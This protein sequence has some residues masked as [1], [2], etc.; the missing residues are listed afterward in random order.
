MTP[1]A[2]VR[3]TFILTSAAV[4]PAET[5]AAIW[6]VD[7]A[8]TAGDGSAW[9]RPLRSV[10]AAVGRA[11]AGDE[12]WLRAGV[13]PVAEPLRLPRGVALVGGFAGHERQADERRGI[14]FA[15]ETTLRLTRPGASVLLLAGVRDVRLD[16]LTLTG[17]SQA[18]A[19]TVAGCGPE[20]RFTHV[21]ITGNSSAVA[22]AAIRITDGSEP[23]FFNCQFAD[24]TSTAPEGGG[25]IFV[26][27][28][29]G[30]S[31]D[32]CI[33]N[34]NV[35]AH[36]SGGGAQIH[37]GSTRA[38]RFARTDFY[39][40]TAAH[41]GSAL[42][43]AGPLELRDCVVAS[44][45]C[46]PAGPGHALAAPGA[47]AR[48]I[49]S[50]QSYVVSNV[51]GRDRPVLVRGIDG[52]ERATLRDGALIAPGDTG[53]ADPAL[54]TS[55]NDVHV[56]LH[57][58]FMPPLTTGAPAPGRWVRQTLPEYAGTAAYHCVYLPADWQ[59][60]RRFPV[61]AG[62]PGN[63]PY[64]NR[65]G[66]RSGGLPEDNPMGVGVSG[67]RGFIVL[68]LGYLDT[69][70]NLQPTG[71]WWGD[72]PA[73]LAYTQAAVRF[74]CGTYGGDPQ[75]IVLFG[76]SRSAIGA[77][78]LGLHDDTI[79]PLWRAFLCYDGWESQADMA[80]DWYRHG[81]SSFGYDPADFGGTGVAR[82]F[83]RL[84]GRPLF[85]LGGRGAVEALNEPHRFPVRLLA[86]PHRNH[87]TSWALRDT[88]ERAAIRDWLA[89]EVGLP[90]N[91]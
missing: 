27:A 71:N 15:R 50:G 79:A 55:R 38:V 25:G 69:R 42:S 44:N 89:R 84:A 31:W 85:I 91:P 83:A 4:L 36:G 28:S 16:G 18:P 81:R 40:N 62:F 9:T 58:V 20:V 87:H 11:R 47:A 78:F 75:A 29:S 5:A 32:L 49:L 37:G 43:T 80:R 59:P 41:T 65:Y 82:R 1:V 88:P 67:G 33:V 76:F 35:A 14:N 7:P 54:H 23:V 61:L 21:R 56:T 68:G 19:V 24:N 86:K 10:G 53:P 45:L 51:A 60:G 26:D 63:G 6:H 17:A 52:E 30:G 34:G 57:D 8:A 48:I 73:T 70:Q 2:L 12:I 39:F 64:R 72:V 66:D 74:V 13:H 77:S 3:V 46:H 90:V 22:G